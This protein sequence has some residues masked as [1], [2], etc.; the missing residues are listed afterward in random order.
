MDDP[1]KG[2]ITITDSGLWRFTFT[3]GAVFAPSSAGDIGVIRLRV[4]GEAVAASFLNP[5]GSGGG[6][7]FSLS[8]NTLQRLEAGQVV[9]TEWDGAGYAYITD[10]GDKYTHWTGQYLGPATSRPP[11]C[12]YAGQTFEYPGSC[13]QY[14]LC[15]EDGSIDVVDCCPDVYVSDAAACLPEDFVL[16]DAVCHSEDVC[17]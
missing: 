16:V 5:E 10:D 14:Y 2:N 4:D 3:A 17:L 11:Q 9:A 1:W 7:L 15:Q 6:G 13:R 12:E 8:I